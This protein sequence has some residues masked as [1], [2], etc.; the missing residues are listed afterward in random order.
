MRK[1]L[2]VIPHVG[3]WIEI[4]QSNYITNAS[5][6]IPHVGMWIEIINQ[7]KSIRI[8]KVIPHVGMWIEMSTAIPIILQSMSSLT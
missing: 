7:S 4:K 2:G 1:R 5:S 3:M 6:V 8:K